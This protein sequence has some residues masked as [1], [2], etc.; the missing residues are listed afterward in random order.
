[1][2]RSY[3]RSDFHVPTR[4]H[5]VCYSYT[6]MGSVAP[7]ML[8]VGSASTLSELFEVSRN[9]AVRYTGGRMPKGEVVMPVRR[10]FK[11]RTSYR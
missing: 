4:K 10:P 11:L 1:M 9:I 5:I 3:A 6:P 8:I 2:H 7:P